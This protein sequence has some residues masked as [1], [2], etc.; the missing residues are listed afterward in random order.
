MMLKTDDEGMILYYFSENRR[1][2]VEGKHRGVIFLTVE[3]IHAYGF[4][5]SFFLDPRNISLKIV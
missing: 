1:V 2:Y 5:Q 3:A 4:Q